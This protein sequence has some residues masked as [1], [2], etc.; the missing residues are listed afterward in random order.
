MA[1]NNRDKEYWLIPKR[2]NLHQSIILTKGILDLNYDLKTWNPSKQ[3]RIGSYLGKNGAT[4]SGRNITPQAIRTLLASIPQYF[5]FLYINNN[6]TPNTIVVTDAGKKLVDYHLKDIKS[7]KNLKEGAS[8]ND[9]INK[10]LFFLKQFE[11]LQITNPILLKDCENI[12]VFPLYVTYVLLLKFKYLD[13]EEIGY[14]LFKIKDHS[15]L[16]LAI[17]EL[18]NFRKMN[19]MDRIKLIDTFKKTSLGNISLVQAPTSTYYIKMLMQTGMFTSKKIEISNPNNIEKIKIKA[20]LLKDEYLSDINKF[21][22]SFDINNIFDFGN[23]L[24]L[25]IDYIGDTS[26][27][28]VPKEIK[29]FNNTDSQYILIIEYKNKIIFS[30][31]IT[32]KESIHVAMF[33]EKEYFFEYIDLTSGQVFKSENLKVTEDIYNNC[34]MENI[35]CPAKNSYTTET[36]KSIGNQIISHTESKNFDEKYTNYLLIIE[37]INGKNY[38]QNKNLRGG[39]LE[40]LF[41]TLLVILKNNSIIDDVYWN[42]KISQY[43]LPTPA[44]GGKM[45]IPDIVFIIN[46]VH[47]L[48]E[49][50]T[51]KAKSMQWSAEG[52]SVP[53]HINHYKNTKN[54]PTKGL[55]VAP[56]HHERVKNGI[57]SQIDED[58]SIDFFTDK[59]LLNLFLSND[60]NNIIKKLS[61]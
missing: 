32:E 41:Y 46:D 60:R 39:R 55:F 22:Q 21:V 8:N 58:T 42:G 27:R 53:D 51:I 59:E 20:I 17:L 31:L 11:K 15:E 30:D 50:T 45:G 47:Y 37:R 38:I 3:D 43:G 4:D 14:I 5:G 36:V 16:N 26:I 44:P 19:L 1:Q 2:A 9:L 24:D 61:I 33:K 34:Y 29:I 54:V 48:L 23:N 13:I 56:I 25:W 28:K 10:S 52:S 6:T 12:F 18:E 57:L 35:D 7:M 40:F 49:L